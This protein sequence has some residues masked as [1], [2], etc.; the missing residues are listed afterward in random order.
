MT[1]KD[2]AIAVFEGQMPDRAPVCDFG[3]VA[4]VGHYGYKQKDCRG[5]VELTKEIMTKWSKETQSDLVFGP[6]ETKGIFMDL[7]GLE[8]KLPDDEQGSLKNA[9]FNTP[10]EIASKPLYD[11]F[12]QKECPNFYKYIVDIFKANHEACTDVMTP[13][14][15]EGVLTTSGFLRGIDTLLMELFADPDNAKKAISRGAEFSRQ[16]VEA[17]LEKFDAD[18]VIYTDPV[19]SADM[20]DDKMFREFNLDHLRKNITGWKKKYGV[21]T[22]LHICGDTTLMLNDL[23]KTGAKVMSLDHAVDL[24][25]ARE[26]L[27]DKTVIMGNIDPVA[28]IYNGSVADVDRAAE[29]CFN[30]AG[31]DGGYIFGAGCSVPNHSPMENVLQMSVVSKRHPY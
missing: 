23:D 12:N 24:S 8:I 20:I 14:W 1:S 30:D 22:M 19:S 15:C 29:K 13:A 7:P 3:N 5:N 4:M 25:V 28:V 17:Q 21:E 27:G 31:R 26:R 2:R 9:Y 16:I 11:P 10:E 18:Y 6:F